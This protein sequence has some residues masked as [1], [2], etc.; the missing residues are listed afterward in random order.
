MSQPAYDPRPIPP[1]AQPLWP[2]A[3]RPLS[4]CPIY[5]A[6]ES[7]WRQQGREVPRL[8]SRDGRRRAPAV[9]LFH[10]G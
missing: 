2:S 9:D 7:Q 6:L 8:A 4:P 1:Q 5:D 10:R 3:G